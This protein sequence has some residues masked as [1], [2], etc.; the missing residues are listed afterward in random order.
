MKKEAEHHGKTNSGTSPAPGPLAQT[1]NRPQG[2]DSGRRELLKTA[3]YDRRVLSRQ[4]YDTVGQSLV[5]LKLSIYRVERSLI[6]Q[7]ENASAETKAI[8]DRVIEQLRDISDSLLP[9]TLEDFGLRK[10]LEEL[11]Q[12]YEESSSTKVE[13]THDGLEERLPID[14]EAGIYRIIRETLLNMMSDL[15]SGEVKV[16]LAVR[17]DAIRLN[18][19]VA[20]QKPESCINSESET[21]IREIAGR[22]GGS[23]VVKELPGK[24]RLICELPASA[25]IEPEG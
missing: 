20:G 5:A 17:G 22:L 6:E 18:I 16:I 8:T 15:R 19:F 10:T 13:F 9:I 2:A 12:R 11:L 24:I 3:D 7:I 1:D 4:L 23:L 25:K 14:I 21:V